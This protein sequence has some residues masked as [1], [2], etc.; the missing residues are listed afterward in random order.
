[1]ADALAVPL[2]AIHPDAGKY[3]CFLAGDGKPERVEVSLGSSNDTMVEV[4]SGLA[5][6]AR[7]LL[8]D[9][10]TGGTKA[11]GPATP[12]GRK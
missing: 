12:E 5:E 6:G 4:K 2:Q 3:Y 1:V 9:P 10:E 7:I 11:A 8:Y